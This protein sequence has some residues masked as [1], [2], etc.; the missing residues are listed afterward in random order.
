MNEVISKPDAV[1]DY[2][3]NM[4]LVDKLDMMVGSVECMRKSIKWYKKLFFHLL[5]G[6]L[7]YS[8]YLYK[9]KTGSR[10]N[11]RKFT[12]SVVKQLLER[13]CVKGRRNVIF[14]ETSES[15]ENV[16]ERL[17]LDEPPNGYP[18]NLCRTQ[19][20]PL[21]SDSFSGIRNRIGRKFETGSAGPITSFFI[22]LGLRP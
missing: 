6:A 7:L 16:Q 22:S 8:F 2:I 17:T 5:D 19:T 15:M 20:F 3:K 1:V 13:Y 9:K 21:T 14:G 4:R 10:T 12:R 18:G 11:Y